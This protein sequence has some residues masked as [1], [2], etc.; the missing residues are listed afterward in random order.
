[1]I[2][3]K[4]HLQ[5][6]ISP[7]LPL[8]YKLN[9]YLLFPIISLSILPSVPLNILPSHI[10]LSIFFSALCQT[11]KWIL[12]SFYLSSP[13][14]N[15]YLISLLLANLSLPFYSF[16]PPF[17]HFIP[18]KTVSSL[19]LCY[20]TLSFFNKHGCANSHQNRRVTDQQSK[21]LIHS[22]T[23]W[24]TSIVKLTDPQQYWSIQSQID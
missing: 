15:V 3:C 16:S 11:S 12:L 23:D 8:S 13:F 2:K 14:P 10:T 22:Q 4:I 21:L 6:S 20:W 7:N 17:S 9:L 19:P 5:H 18:S 1:M 24:S